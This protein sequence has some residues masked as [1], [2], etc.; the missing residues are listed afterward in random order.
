MG[1]PLIGA[2]ECPNM[3]RPTKVNDTDV[4]AWLAQN[5][6]WN[7]VGD[8]LVRAYTFETFSRALAF[9]VEIG[10]LAEKHDHHPD[11]ELGWGKARLLWTTH[12]AGGITELDQR[13]AQAS[14]KTYG[15]RA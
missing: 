14:D 7:K 13:L 10:M 12:D 11:V 5:P 3:T 9:V 8:A 4:Q 2:L 15:P 1:T 6:G